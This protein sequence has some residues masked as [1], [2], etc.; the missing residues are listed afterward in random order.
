VQGHSAFSRP[1]YVKLCGCQLVLH[2]PAEVLFSNEKLSDT[3][4]DDSVSLGGLNT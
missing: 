4:L 2:T 1:T 3:M